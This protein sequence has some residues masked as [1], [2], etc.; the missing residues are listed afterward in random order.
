MGLYLAVDG[1]QTTTKMVLADGQGTVLAVATGEPSNHT[2]RPGGPERLERVIIRMVEAVLREARLPAPEL[3]EFAA[4]CFGMTGETEIKRRVLGRLIRTP[5][6]TVVHDS[7]NALIGATAGEPGIIVIAGTGSVARA[8]DARGREMRASGW[9]YL[10]GDEGSAYWIGREAV[11]AISAEYDG[12][13]EKTRLTSVFR[14]RLG[15][16]NPYDL[17]DKYY[18]GEWSHNHLA[19]L[20][21]WVNEVAEAG[22]PVAQN[23]LKTAGE[24]LSQFATRLLD[25]LDWGDKASIVTSSDRKRPAVCYTGGAFESR[26]VLAS[27]REAILGKHPQVEIHPP[28]LP[29]VLGSLLLA[30]RSTGVEI[31]RQARG[32]WTASL[33]RLRE[34]AE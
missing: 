17:M 31:S 14:E 21:V 10:F 28:V 11:R 23:I 30:Y 3:P 29:P 15:I 5:H 4:A 12:F 7:V 32:E 33:S 19:G 9:G 1:G 18:S 8:M 6:L 25:I 27:F 34:P 16:A 26:F 22:D 24:I 20:A 13:G 2:E